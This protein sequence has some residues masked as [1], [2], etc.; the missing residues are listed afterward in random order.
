VSL[1][2]IDIN[3][4]YRTLMDNVARH[5]IVPALQ[6]SN[7][8]DRAVGFFSSTALLEISKGIGKFVENGGKMRLIAS[9]HL[10]DEDIDAISK[11]YEDRL[12]VVRDALLGE[13]RSPKNNEEADRLNLLANL[14]ASGVLDIKIAFTEKNSHIGIYHEKVGILKDADNNVVAFSGSMNESKNAYI[15][16][17]EA[18]D[19]FCSWNDPEQRTA[20]KTA[21]FD[22]IWDGNEPGI[23]A[24]SFP[25][26]DEEIIKKYKRGEPNFNIDSIDALPGQSR[27]DCRSNTN[28]FPQLPQNLKLREYQDEAIG[29]WEASGYR[30]IFDMATGT[31]KTKTG[32]GALTRL[33]EALDHELAAIIV[34]PY[35]HLVEQWV[36][37]IVQFNINPIVGYG[38]S[39][40]KD[41]FSFL[42]NTIRDQRYGVAGSQFL[43]F[44][45]TNGTFRTK[46]VQDE[47]E[48]IRARKLLVVDEAHNF[49]AEY[50][51]SLLNDDY[52]YRLALSA[53]IE[54]HGDAEGTDSLFSFFGNRCIRYSLEEAILGRGDEPPRLTPYKYYPVF[55]TLEND[56]LERYSSLSREIAR[57]FVSRNGKKVLSEKGKMLTLARARIVAGARG[58]IDALEK[59]IFPYKN[60]NFILVY[61]GATKVVD[62]DDSNENTEVDDERQIEVVKKLLG[63]KLRMVVHQFTSKESRKERDEIK[64]QFAN[65]QGYQALVAIKCLDEGVDIPSIKTAFI[66]ASTTNPREYIQRRG[67]LLRQAEGKDFA[68]IY[69]FVTLP[70][71]IG[72]VTSLTD[73]ETLGDRRL[74]YNELVRA[75]EF[76]RLALNASTASKELSEIEEA[77]FGINGIDGFA[78]VEDCSE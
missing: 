13:L 14:I 56:E 9:P 26:L 68:E 28:S 42:K 4:E 31:G 40:Q 50:L 11:G 54:R 62:S 67:R 77:Y 75:K 70:R 24:I 60:E 27:D 36:D 7:E 30:G 57:C 78:K 22:S 21:G 72:A 1:K 74:V 5:F 73:E 39:S 47:L 17:Y 37:D 71:K 46:K 34:C 3:L 2:D 61:C 18:I 53:T 43:C 64:R 65:G 32:L 38:D 35:Q 63:N 10:S 48:K 44:I 8:Y 59:S 15:N 45:C 20:L 69:D 33:S 51:R 55:V 16:N 52:D 19:V 58:K 66:L 76:A 29:A 49:G 41:W 6:E 12:K 25:E 23:S